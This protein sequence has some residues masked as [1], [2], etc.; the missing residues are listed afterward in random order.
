[1]IGVFFVG[2]IQKFVFYVRVTVKMNAGSDEKRRKDVVGHRFVK[3]EIIV[4]HGLFDVV[5]V[6]VLKFGSP[7]DNVSSQS[8]IGLRKNI[9]AKVTAKEELVIANVHVVF[10]IYENLFLGVVGSATREQ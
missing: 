10:C 3:F 9:I 4:I 5:V 6:K 7:G 2:D 8:V 1:M